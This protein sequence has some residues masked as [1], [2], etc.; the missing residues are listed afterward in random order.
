MGKMKDGCR[1]IHEGVDARE[2]KYW[3]VYDAETGG[4]KYIWEKGDVWAG[5]D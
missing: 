1:I 5:F 3:L 2:N 4:S